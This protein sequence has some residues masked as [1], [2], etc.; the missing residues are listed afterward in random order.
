VVVFFHTA[1][2]CKKCS[3]MFHPF[4]QAAKEL[5]NIENLEFLKYDTVINELENITV[6]EPATL[7]IYVKGKKD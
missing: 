1:N 7:R 5:Q 6:P 2:G 3:Q 4:S